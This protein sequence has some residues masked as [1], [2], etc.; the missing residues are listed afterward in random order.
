MS[1]HSHHHGHDHGDDDGLS[2][3]HDHSHDE[4]ETYFIDQLCMVGLSGAF[5]VICLCLWFWQTDMLKN[6]L[7]VQFHLYVLL[8]GIA[9]VVIAFTRGWILWRQSRDPAFVPGHDHDHAH[10]HGHEHAVQE[11]STLQL[12]VKSAP[13]HEHGSALGHEHKP[14]GTGGHDHEHHGSSAPHEH[15]IGHAHAHH[16]HDEADHDH[17]WAPW[18]YVVILVP[19]ILFLLGLPNQPP[20]ITDLGHERLIG[21][22]TSIIYEALPFIVLGVFLA[23]LLEEFVPQ[24]AIAKIVPR[25]H[26]L[27]IAIGALLGLVFPM[28]EC[29]IIVVMKRLLRKGLPLSVCVAYMLAGPVIN[30]VVMGSTFVAFSSYNVEG[31]NDVLGGPWHVLAWRVGLSY[32][33]AIVTAL[34]VHW[35]WTKHGKRLI[36]PSV[37]RGLKT[38][39]PDEEYSIAKRPWTERIN[40]ITQTALNDF[41]DIMAFLV[42]GSL[43]AAGGKF[44]IRESNVQDLLRETPAVA[45]LLMMAIAVLFCLCSEAD[46]FVAANFPL[47]WPDGSKLAFLVLGPMFDLK[48]LMMFTR[49][50]RA[51][52]IYTIVIALV[53][54]VFAYTMVVEAIFGKEHPPESAGVI[55]SPN[56]ETTHLVVLGIGVGPDPLGQLVPFSV[57]YQ[58]SGEGQKV[59]YKTFIEMA[60]RS[61]LRAEWKPEGGSGR[62]IEVRGQYEP[63]QGSDQIFMLSR[64]QITCCRSDVTTLRAPVISRESIVGLQHGAWVKVT[65]R[66][67]FRERAPGSYQTILIVTKAADVVPCHPDP[68]PYVQ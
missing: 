63:Y 13:A 48:L 35:Q 39:L 62:V 42:L 45:I 57:G 16:D 19:I 20:S 53:V 5:G 9:L 22:F 30:V 8:S 2:H 44:L 25:N 3:D 6:L 1:D 52:L 46:A 29:G 41:V 38:S 40:N 64:L 4:P 60:S 17:G 33:V 65:G 67:D 10:E 21:D 59:S 27:A 56:E 58:E 66:V 28:C 37:L 55:T 31:K 68:D 14:A 23:G 50:Y 54:Q 51:R 34:I 43:L 47:F 12:A 24:Q 11:K 7:A 49:V 18:R 32:I 15:T 61:D 26:V 36:H